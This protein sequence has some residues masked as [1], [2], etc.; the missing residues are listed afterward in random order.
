MLKQ[1]WIIGSSTYFVRIKRR[2]SWVW[3][4]QLSASAHKTQRSPHWDVLG[5][6]RSHG[7]LAKIRSSEWPHVLNVTLNSRSRVRNEVESRFMRLR[8]FRVSNLTNKVIDQCAITLKNYIYYKKFTNQTN[9]TNFLQ[10]LTIHT[11]QSK[12]HIQP[13]KNQ[14]SNPKVL[15]LKD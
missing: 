10:Y 12:Q 6:L 13:T 3:T 8:S 1:S 14:K 4:P 5:S 15:I 11:I 7:A 2:C 9:T